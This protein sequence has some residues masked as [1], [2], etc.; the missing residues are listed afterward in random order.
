MLL[1]TNST[2]DLLVLQLVAHGLCVGVLALVLLVL[3]PVG[4]WS[5]D[6]VLSD[7]RGVVRGAGGVLCG[8]AKLCP[9]L[10]VGDAGV[11]DLTVGDE[12]DAAGC[13]DFLSLV[14][15]LV[16]DDRLGAITVLDRLLRRELVDGRDL[17]ILVIVGPVTMKRR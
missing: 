7:G 17:V 2:L 10:A 16:A 1:R 13:L 9:C 4:G 11:H 15:V 8:L 5:E 12:A 14:V 6:D 3:A